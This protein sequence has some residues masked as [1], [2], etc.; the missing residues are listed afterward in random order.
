MFRGG[1]VYPAEVPLRAL[2]FV[3]GLI[4]FSVVPVHAQ[5][6]ACL[7]IK[8]QASIKN[9]DLDTVRD[10]WFSWVNGAREKAGA[11][12]LMQDGTLTATAG[13][14]SLYA[15]LRGFIDH[16]RALG[17]PYYDYKG[18][19]KWFNKWGITFA[20]QGNSTFSE[21]I[22]WGIYSCKAADCTPALI[23][24]IRTTYAMYMG[25]QG[26]GGPHYRAMVNANYTLA[27]VGV[28]VN[29]A[30]GRYYLTMH[31]AT[32]ITSPP[33]SVCR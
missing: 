22:G 7:A 1:F 2:I 16:K 10:T 25:E 8:T 23:E 32:A 17:A 30:Q 26:K 20:N 13:N 9:V 19:G 24:S 4:L 27:G 31:Y 3:F 12:P 11:A 5:D 14:W 28:A 29:P 18:I 6:D 33:L 21:S 15:V